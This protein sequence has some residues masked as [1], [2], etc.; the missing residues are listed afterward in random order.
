MSHQPDSVGIAVLGLTV[1]HRG[2]RS[3]VIA[4]LPYGATAAA[5]GRALTAEI[6]HLPAFS[7]IHVVR[8]GETLADASVVT[9]C[10]VRT[11]D[12]LILSATTAPV[13]L[14]VGIDIALRRPRGRGEPEV[15]VRGATRPRVVAG[16]VAQLSSALAV[17]GIP[18]G[19]HTV[20][21]TDWS[22]LVLDAPGL[23]DI[24]FEV[25]AADDV[26]EIVPT[27]SGPSVSV[28]GTVLSAQGMEV[29]GRGVIR[30]GVA[31]VAIE[32]HADDGSSRRS[33]RV[34]IGDQPAGKTR[35]DLAVGGD[36]AFNRPPR[37]AQAWRPEKL[38]LPE[39]PMPARRVRLPFVAALVPLIAG[40]VMFLLLDSVLMLAFMAL[41]PLMAAGTYISDRRSGRKDHQ[42]SLARFEARLGDVAHRAAIAVDVEARQ[43]RSNHPDIT[44]VTRIAAERGQ[45]L[46][47]RRAWDR[48][49]LSLRLGLG[50]LPTLTELSVPRQHGTDADPRVGALA[51]AYREVSDVPY[52]LAMAELSTV[53]FAGTRSVSIDAARGLVLQA[54]VLHSP[55]DLGIAAAIPSGA[56]GGWEWLKWL[57]HA[58]TGAG[59]IGGRPLATGRQALDLLQR[60]R[61][62]QR[63]VLDDRNARYAADGATDR[64]ALLVV[65]DEELQLERSLVAEVLD[66]ARALRTAVIWIGR[67]P[68]GLPGQCRVTVDATPDRLASVVE[69]DTG[70]E[71]HQIRLEGVSAVAAHRVARELAPMSDATS[72]SAAAAIPGR[73][74]LLEQI[75]LATPTAEHVAELWQ[76][77]KRGLSAAIGMAAGEPLRI[78]LRSDGPHALIAG[79]TGAGKSELLRTVVASLAAEH[80]PTKLTF[81][82]ID[83][84]GGAA[85]APCRALPH[86]LDVVSDLDAEL[87]ERALVS[88][89]AEMK[90][91][92]QLLADARADNLI[93]LERRAPELAPPNLVIMVDEFA[94]LRDEIPQFIDGVVDVAQ[95]GRALGI[96]MILAAQSLRT[97]FTP[98]VRA[99]T[100]LR[101]ALRVASDV[102]SEDVIEAND[103]A[104]IPSGDAARGRA[105]ARIGHDHLVEFQA[106]HV[107]GRFVD[108]SQAEIGVRPF[109]FGSVLASSSRRSGADESVPAS[110]E[111][112]L[113]HL[114][115]ACAGAAH[116]LGLPAPRAA[117]APPLTDVIP[118]TTIQSHS[119]PCRGL[120]AI[121]L[122]DQ[123]AR[124]RQIPLVLNFDRG[125]VAVFGTGG[126]GKTMALQTV[127]AAMAVAASPERLAI[128]AI[129]AGGAAL[130]SIAPLPHVGAVIDVQD[131]ER[132]ERL[133]ARLEGIVRE[134][135]TRFAAIGAGTLTEYTAK[136]ADDE[137]PVRVVLLLDGIGEFANAYDTA[138]A[139]SPFERLVT[140]LASGRS[141]GVHIML[142][143]DR[144]SALR[145]AAAAHV[146]QRIV[147]RLA[148]AEDLVAFGIPSR[149]A[150]Q[151]N[152]PAGRGFTSDGELVQL[153]L[154][155][156]A[157]GTDVAEGFRLLGAHLGD[158]WP[159]L[160]APA[161]ETLPDRVSF[162]RLTVRRNTPS[163][164]PVAVGGPDLAPQGIDLSE[165]H[166]LV[167]GPY[168]SGRSS[169][170]AVIAEQ[171][172]RADT[173]HELHLLAPR[174][175]C[176]LDR[177]FWSSTARGVEACAEA[178]TT[179]A[180]RIEERPDT[181]GARIV[182][183]I[184]D[185][186]ELQDAASWLALE[187]IVR[188]GRDRGAR[189]VAAAETSSARTMTNAWLRELRRDGQGALMMPDSTADGDILG[190][191]LPRR[192]AV[193]MVPGRGY[194]VTRG[195]A[196]LA[197]F[198][199][200]AS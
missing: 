38:P 160:S 68:L 33:R 47:E 136:V 191:L 16:S 173:I 196:T 120:C 117:W 198:A 75:G 77:P 113:A 111:T 85:F 30:V 108:A 61:A 146:S 28:N 126:S 65:I 182:V 177:T 59:L 158:A 138:R 176:L 172:H 157:D 96:H 73:V 63:R 164:L 170:L 155:Q 100:N 82:L 148:A 53:G 25:N 93:D 119:D 89:D 13:D 86:V 115:R 2:L 133:I 143:A 36:L 163:N 54:A 97:A 171:A 132:V 6:P 66:N 144:R 78:D 178:A 60:L 103:A 106:A 139:G 56:E 118:R 175:T 14:D 43:R 51:A 32:L 79:M 9:D 49:F 99:N 116:V 24:A 110:D 150:E 70:V 15:I 48:D 142:T 174:R 109:T 195:T 72:A 5:L 127:A 187:R 180:S 31:E 130:S 168:R 23:P 181:P 149:V 18:V 102:E 193:A 41:A 189:V 91:R 105:F 128:Y 95:R 188:L 156:P 169:A 35:V 58:S 194:L 94:K 71:R 10:D 125:N 152:L 151:V 129:D 11:G 8:T 83:Y 101:I 121:G 184:D 104:R 39:T 74:R 112:D 55:A 62:E 167:S 88:L 34:V 57:P 141:M 84:K 161:V 107:S 159:G 17:V 147:L 50:T 131:E 166:F 26:V 21:A 40:F 80:P 19:R 29:R 197:Q 192:H 46:W 186:G 153:A 179:L 154:P 3:D 98:A 135:S 165:R 1:E 183:V 92:E 140:L 124:Q 12:T 64:P 122:V 44:T 45:R 27:R 4:E 200:P 69:I 162:R 76:R 145:P 52:V 87:G 20:G 137:A 37:R 90:R 67:D 42:E 185:G 134:R 199:D 123:P 190:A 7:A 22:D 81:L 114:T